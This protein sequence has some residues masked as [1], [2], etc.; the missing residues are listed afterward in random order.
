MILVYKFNCLPHRDRSYC[1]KLFQGTG[2]DCSPLCLSTFFIDYH[3]QSDNSNP[4]V[5]M[6]RQVS[7]LHASY[8]ITSLGGLWFGAFFFPVVFAISVLLQIKAVGYHTNNV[9]PECNL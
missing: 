9:V 6:R 5:L 7:H 2:G 4:M 3:K 1:L 8:A